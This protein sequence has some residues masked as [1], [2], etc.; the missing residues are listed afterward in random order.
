MNETT[1]VMTKPDRVLRWA[2]TS[3]LGLGVLVLILAVVAGPGYRAELVQLSTSFALLRVA[4]WAGVGVGLLS[5]VGLV[6]A[7]SRSR[8][9]E[10]G[11]L[12]VAAIVCAA[13]FLPVRGLQSDAQA[14]PPI[15]DV[16]TDLADPPQFAAIPP[17]VEDPLRVP[18]RTEELEALTP[19]ERYRVYH[20]RAYGDLSA[21]SL[22]L[23][24][25]DALKAAEAAA[26]E[27]GWEVVALTPEAGR[28]EATS[29]TA[30]FGFKDDVVVRVRPGVSGG[31]RVDVRSVSRIGVSD[32]GANAKRIEAFLERL[33]A[34]AESMS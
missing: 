27:M 8:L 18:A 28:L 22:G 21:L 23:A 5:L 32:L 24:P 6:L 4:A 3:L 20:E 25:A 16:T 7:M 2:A 12:A 33:E 1:K 17:R 9:R 15:H 14:Y 10:A 11:M 26:R 31:S 13:V 30:W 34:A 29:T 19:E